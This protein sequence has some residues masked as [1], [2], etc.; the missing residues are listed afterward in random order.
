MFRDLALF[1]ARAVLRSEGSEKGIVQRLREIGFAASE[2]MNVPRFPIDSLTVLALAM[3]AYLV[4]M[5]VI[6][7]RVPGVPSQPGGILLAPSKIALARLFAVGVTVWLMQ[8]YSMFRRLPGRPPRFF[9]YVLCGIIA[10]AVSAA[11]CLIFRLGDADP[12]GGIR[13]DLPVILLS[14]MLCTA[15]ALCCD[16]WTEDRPPPIW[17]R[18]VEAL[19]CALVMALGAALVYFADLLP[20]LSNGMPR[21]M[22]VAWIVLPSI[23]ALLIGGWVP[24]IYRS[25]RRAAM[26]QRGE[27]YATPARARA[28]ASERLA[29]TSPPSFANALIAA[30]RS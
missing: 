25:A 9:G 18:F 23:M 11:I 3:F 10:A 16:D 29:V 28:S 22:P 7:A 27:T 4:T 26:S 19:G 15:V 6:F 24:H 30:S 17:L 12:L 8:N 2:P 5:S 13:D 1:L 21:W 14:G 20:F